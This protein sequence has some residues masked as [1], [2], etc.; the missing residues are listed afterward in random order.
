MS[1]WMTT[2]LFL[3]GSAILTHWVPFSDFFRNVDTMV[4]ELGH[5]VATMVLSG[6]V[7]Y[8][9]LYANHSGVTYSYIESGWRTIPLGLAGYV[10]ASAFA[11][12]LFRQYGKGKLGVGFVAM[13]LLAVVSLAFFVN[14]SFG[15]L[16]LIGFIVV[17]GVAMLVPFPFLRKFYYLLVAFIC[18]EES[19]MGPINLIYMSVLDPTRAGDASGLSR[20]TGI[21][22]LAWAILFLIVSLWCARSAIYSFMGK[23]RSRQAGRPRWESQ[24]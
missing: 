2:I 24:A 22:A 14:N 12:F 17:N 6:E 5:A 7:L 18:L 20:S 21:P 9:Q 4:H 13:S 23:G 15:V 10:T 19:V 16:W 3:V 1:R 11:A 8:I